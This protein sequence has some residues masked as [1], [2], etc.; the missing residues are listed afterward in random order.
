MNS[1]RGEAAKVFC[2]IRNHQPQEGGKQRKGRRSVT[3]DSV[4]PCG[5]QPTGSSIHGIFQARIPEWVAISFFR[6][7][8]LTQGFNLGLPHCRQM[9]YCLSHTR[10][11][12]N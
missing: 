1:S 12:I 7:P 4:R 9:L 2:P 8:S 10:N 6:R 11:Q 3:F 5:L